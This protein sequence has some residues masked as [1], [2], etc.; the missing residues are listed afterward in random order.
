MN[1]A[2]HNDIV[3]LFP[4][5]PDHAVLEIEAMQAT[6]GELDAALLAFTSDDEPLIEFRQREGGR[7]NQLLQILTAAGVDALDDRDA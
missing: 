5:L 4:G 1:T 6:V 7:I 3:R 2:T